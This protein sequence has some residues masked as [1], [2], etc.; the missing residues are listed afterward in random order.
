MQKAKIAVVK[1]CR[2][3]LFMFSNHLAV[4]SPLYTGLVFTRTVAWVNILFH[5][6]NTSRSL[7]V[8]THIFVVCGCQK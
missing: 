4:V 1:C 6:M 3:R 8:G 2:F 5:E 7:K